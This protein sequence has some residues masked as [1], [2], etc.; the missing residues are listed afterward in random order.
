MATAA[1]PA[2]TAGAG[3]STL[4]GKDGQIWDEASTVGPAARPKTDL[5][6]MHQDMY[7]L[8]RPMTLKPSPYQSS[9]SVPYQPRKHA[10][11]TVNYLFEHRMHIRP[12][13]HRKQGHLYQIG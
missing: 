6:E 10:P 11:V 1:P 2:S 7:Q 3:A 12:S 8:F 4:V 9:A 13:R 5:E